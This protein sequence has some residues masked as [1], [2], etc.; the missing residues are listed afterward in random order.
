MNALSFWTGFCESYAALPGCT[1]QIGDAGALRLFLSDAFDKEEEDFDHAARGIGGSC[2]DGH[3]PSASSGMFDSGDDGA[4]P[5]FFSATMNHV[6]VGYLSV[7]VAADRSSAY[8]RQLAVNPAYHRRGI[9]SAIFRYLLDELPTVRVVSVAC[10][11]WNTPAIRLYEKL[12]FSRDMSCH[13]TLDP[14]VYIGF[15]WKRSH[16]LHAD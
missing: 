1:E 2:D 10:R 8:L 14:A 5:Q 9:A 11:A 13:E 15:S 12:G 4:A 3:V 16:S 6:L 7:D